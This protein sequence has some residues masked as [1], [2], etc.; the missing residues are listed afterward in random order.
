MGENR[1][2]VTHPDEKGSI[3]ISEE[4]IS[5]IAASAALETEGVASL[6]SGLDITE[7]LSKKTLGRGVRITVDGENVKVDVWLTVRLGVSVH[8]VGHKVQET[9]ASSI[10]SATG[11]AVT[12]VNVHI[13]GVTLGK[14]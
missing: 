2:Y 5:A 1:D 11:F 3:N 10:E 8:K 4:V 14:K 6:S 12:E 13:V 7:L 9:V